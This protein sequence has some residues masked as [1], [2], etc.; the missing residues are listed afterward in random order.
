MAKCP[1][2]DAHIAIDAQTCNHCPA[3]FG[4]E[5]WRPTPESAEEARVV[6]KLDLPLT[7]DVHTGLP[8]WARQLTALAV[9][10]VIVGY[11]HLISGANQN[12][13]D[14]SL[15][16]FMFIT[17]HLLMVFAVLKGRS[18][19]FIF[20]VWL[21]VIFSIGAMVNIF[22]AAGPSTGDASGI[23]FVPLMLAA[24]VLGIGGII[25]AQ[26]SKT[27]ERWRKAQEVNATVDRRSDDHS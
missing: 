11:V 22:L 9:A 5:G 18:S 16:A 24:W 17:P 1:N 13:L 10:P 12:R 23:L 7:P 26:E 14:A 2:C 3:T 8:L 27:K 20:F 6:A 4:S 15:P 19:G 21:Y 25:S